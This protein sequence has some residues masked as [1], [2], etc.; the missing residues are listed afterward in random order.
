MHSSPL[1][2]SCH[3]PSL[4]TSQNRPLYNV[5]AQS[6]NGTVKAPS[7]AITSTNGRGFGLSA[8]HKNLT[9]FRHTSINIAIFIR[10]AN[11][12]T[13]IDP[14]NLASFLTANTTR[15]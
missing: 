14:R 1:P 2:D 6:S 5:I 7:A 15:F 9:K 12:T 11:I 4:R 3:W 8:Y 13:N 10:L